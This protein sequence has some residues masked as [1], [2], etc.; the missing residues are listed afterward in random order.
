MKGILSDGDTAVFDPAFTPATVRLPLPLQCAIPGSGAMTV[1]GRNVCLEEDAARVQLSGCQYVS[2][3]YQIIPG[4]C[5][6]TIEKVLPA[7][8][9]RG[10]TVKGA[11]LLLVGGPF[12]AKLTVTMP[13]KLVTPSGPQDDPVSQYIGRGEFSNTHTQFRTT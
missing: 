4:L 6:L 7:Q 8:L 11:K 9:S 3:P 13:A 2:G 5:D 1:G 10:F 12:I